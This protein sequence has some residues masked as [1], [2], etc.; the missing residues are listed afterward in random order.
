[1]ANAPILVFDIET[2]PDLSTGKRLYPELADLPDK[3][4]MTALVAMREAE[5]GNPFMVQPLHAVACFSYLWLDDNTIKL[6]SFCQETMSEAQILNRV[7]DAFG[8]KPIIISWN[9]AGF[10]LPVLLYR[11]TY[12][13]LN[14]R[15]IT[16]AGFKDKDYLNRY[17]SM[18]LDLMDKFSFGAWGNKQKLDVV[19]SLCG[20]AGKGQID[21]RAVLPMVQ[22]GQWYDLAVYCESDVLN[23]YLLYLRYQLLIGN[24]NHQQ[25]DQ[26][27]VQLL[28]YLKTLKNDNGQ[29]RHERFFV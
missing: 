13:K 20:F 1:M 18:H 4:A 17:S 23:T 3:D 5:A 2:I 14:A 7:L 21:G 16:H 28:S 6:G 22:Q 27:Y 8:K 12:H 10:D 15:A 19:A 26:H 25:H 24:I 9:G 11:M 29:L